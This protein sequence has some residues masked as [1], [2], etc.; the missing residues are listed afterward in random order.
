MP[1]VLRCASYS[2]RVFK[3]LAVVGVSALALA[4]CVAVPDEPAPE[5]VEVMPPPPPPPAEVVEPEPPGFDLSMFS[6]D[7]ADSLWVVVNKL[8][9]LNPIDF[10]PT[11]LVTPDVP[12]AFDPL[13]RE[14]VARALEDMYAEA[15]TDG[16]PFRLQSSY[17]SYRL[18]QRVK[19]SSVQRLGQTVSDQRSARPG[20]SEHQTGLAVDLTTQSGRCTLDAC[21]ADT[22][23]GIWLAENAWRFGFILRYLDGKSD[24]HGYIFEPWHFRYVGP[25]L[26]EEIHLQGN[27]T[28]E[29]LFG[30]D[31]APDYAGPPPPAPA[32]SPAPDPAPAPAPAPEPAPN[33]GGEPGRDDAGVPDFPDD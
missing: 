31:P 22:P 6:I 17:R 33:G 23:E 15:L 14:V 30:L 13:V 27:P 24:I 8:R 12:A 19:A 26:A 3:T 25:E 10:A 2:R 7:E 28:L 18:Q 4:G 1:R 9:P 5:V 16:V 29:E 21:F 11:D 20:H 32:P